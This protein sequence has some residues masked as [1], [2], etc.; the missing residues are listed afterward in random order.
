MRRR[1]LI[2]TDH[3]V[4]RFVE[5]C[6]PSLTHDEARVELAGTLYRLVCVGERSDGGDATLYRDPMRP[7]R[8]EFVVARGRIVTITNPQL[9][10]DGADHVDARV[11]RR[12]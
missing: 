7:M 12:G 6:E 4:E 1:F 10:P 11:V 5:R 3:A 2:L 9:Q 8:A